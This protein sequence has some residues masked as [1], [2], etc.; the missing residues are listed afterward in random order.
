MKI[1]ALV[2]TDKTEERTNKEGKAVSYRTLSVV[3]QDETGATLE[4][5]AQVGIKPDDQKAGKSLAGS[6]VNLA[7]RSI[8]DDWRGLS[9]RC[10]LLNVEGAM[11]FVSAKKA[12]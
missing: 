5:M 11:Q 2:I 4:S 10:D 8:Q 7:I 9:F 12:A 3:D 6:V 1:R